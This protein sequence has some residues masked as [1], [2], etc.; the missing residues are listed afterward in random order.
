M[1]GVDYNRSKELE[2]QMQI[3]A[4]LFPEMGI[5]SIAE[6]FSQL[7]KALAVHS[8]NAQ[9]SM[10]QRDHRSNK[11]VIGL[12]TEKLVGSSFQDITARRVIY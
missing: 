11:F 5:R 7:K 9:M 3:G 12:G 6:S 8:S 1:S 10:V 2:F 4:K